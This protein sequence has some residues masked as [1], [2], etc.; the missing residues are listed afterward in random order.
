MDDV[1]PDAFHQ[2]VINERDGFDIIDCVVE[3][4]F[5]FSGE[6]FKKQFRL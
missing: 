5:G 6:Q 2:K 1:S 4:S 3:S